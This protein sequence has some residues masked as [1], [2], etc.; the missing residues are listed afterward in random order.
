MSKKQI[1]VS[2]RFITNQ[3]VNCRKQAMPT[4]QSV[5]AYIT[6][7]QRMPRVMRAAQSV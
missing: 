1:S 2:Y 7:S 5:S 3:T 4:S 6:T